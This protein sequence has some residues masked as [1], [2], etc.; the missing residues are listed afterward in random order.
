MGNEELG[1]GEMEQW[2]IGAMEKW[3]I[4]ELG[5]CIY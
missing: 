4:G 1:N 3:R 2:R 5:F